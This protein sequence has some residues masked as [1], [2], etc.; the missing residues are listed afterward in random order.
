MSDAHIWRKVAKSIDAWP[1][2][3]VVNRRGREPSSP[4]GDDYSLQTE[5]DD[6]QHVITAHPGIPAVFGWS[7]GGLIALLLTEQTPLPHVIAYEPVIG[8]FAVDALA[9][10]RAAHEQADWDR[11]VEIVNRQIAG[12]PASHVDALRK[13]RHAWETL[14]R[15]SR[16]LY[17][18][19]VALNASI[20]DT[21]GSQASRVD[22]IVGQ[23][24]R[25]RPPYGTSFDDV[26]ERTTAATV[27][28]LPGQGHMA[29][30]ENPV[31]LA[32]FVNALGDARE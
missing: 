7:Y 16:P 13:D 6:L 12:L 30:L 28:E 3:T 9:A 10:L 19:S 27:H 25:G 4:L 18:E 5:V 8:P 22:L 15:L 23:Q 11:S 2:V 32:Q 21:L 26:T 29:H 31:A 17:A 20:P 1:S 24:N 14:R